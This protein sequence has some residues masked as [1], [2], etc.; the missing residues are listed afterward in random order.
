[1]EYSDIFLPGYDNTIN[2]NDDKLSDFKQIDKGHNIIYMELPHSNGTLRKTKIDIYTS[3]GQGSK[4]RDGETGVYYNNR[5]GSLDEDLFY[6][7]MLS[8]GECTSPNGSSTLFFLSPQHY[9]SH[10]R[11]VV[12]DVSISKWA[13]KRAYRIKENNKRKRGNE[14]VV[15]N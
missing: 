9:M 10:M 3:G 4:I 11:V 2:N 13:E 1:M 8:T 5:V 15:V 14:S 6:K 12:D 7:V